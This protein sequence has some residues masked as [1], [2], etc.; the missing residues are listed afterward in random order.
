[1]ALKVLITGGS[2]LLGKYL[3]STQPEGVEVESTWYSNYVGSLA[4]H[5]LNLTDKSQVRYLFDLVQPQLVIHCA[6]NGS[7]DYAERN[8]A[9][10]KSINVDGTENILQ[11][12]QSY[13]AKVVYISSNAVFDG[14]HPPYSEDSDCYPINAY[15]SVKKWAEERV[16]KY[17][18]DWQIFRPYL[19]YGWPWPNGR[20]NWVTTVID[21]LGKDEAMKLVNDVTW[22]P[23][24]AKDC[25]E[26]IWELSTK[27]NGIYHV[28]SSERATLYEFGLK[29]AKVFQLDEK[30]LEP[31][32]S[33]LFSTMAPR[34]KDTTYNL[35]KINRLGIELGSIEYG[36]ERMKRKE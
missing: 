19:L 28:A 29:V 5:Q 36:L 17:K 25:A 11:A 14:D 32:D 34:P 4:G 9:D 12:A 31:V 18:Y 30:L 20:A 7:V 27:E 10:A 23:T 6:A 35:D 15:G 8:Y 3:L 2:S 24:Y 21:K 13:R 22:M 33:N 26:A 1:M 16:V